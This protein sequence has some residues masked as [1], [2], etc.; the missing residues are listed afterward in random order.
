MYGLHSNI[1]FTVVNYARLRLC[2]H[3]YEYAL[4]VMGYGHLLCAW[5]DRVREGDRHIK[6]AEEMMLKLPFFAHGIRLPHMIQFPL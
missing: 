5:D 4:T 1:R 3:Q 6:D 2:R